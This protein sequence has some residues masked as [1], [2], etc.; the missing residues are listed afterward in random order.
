[1]KLSLFTPTNNPQHLA[2]TYDSLKLQGYRNFEWTL[3]PNGGLQPNAIPEHIRRDPRVVIHPYEHKHI[4]ALKRYAC[5]RSTG[6]AFIE[7]DHDDSLVPG[8]LAR[9]AA[10]FATG[11]GFVYSDVACFT[12]KTLRPHVYA[13]DYGWENY[14]LR[15]YNR[16]FYA[17]RTFPVSARS[18]CAVHY[19]PDHVRS[20][21]RAAYYKAGGHD[22][23]LLVADD[24]DLLCRTYLTGAEFKHTGGCEY[25]YRFHADNT[26]K[27]YND[28]IQRLQKENQDKYLWRLID[29]ELR[30]TGARFETL[31]PGY[32]GHGPLPWP[33][34]SVGCLK[35]WNTLQLVPTRRL[36]HVL[37]EIYRVLRP[38]G[39]LCLRAPSTDGRGAFLPRHRSLWNEEVVRC[40]C[41]GDDAKLQLPSYRGRFQQVRCWTKY[42][43]DEE[44]KR[45]LTSVYAD[46]CCIKNQRLP[47]KKHI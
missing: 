13:A 47:G 36:P 39:W 31:P 19:A 10:A 35:A 20:W 9:I 28:D 5:D 6:D 46:L 40:L 41:Y 23:S 43:S 24:H 18:L 44:K 8:A 12:D 14:P 37:N 30:R 1:M 16:V 11:A 15:L 7:L 4:G 45:V 3:V 29:E 25:L 27:K 38:G 42:P 34:D 22:P 2:E 26:V 21:S 17:T 33:D 32:A